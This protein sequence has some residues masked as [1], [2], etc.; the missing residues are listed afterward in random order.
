MHLAYPQSA[1]RG[2]RVSIPI[3]YGRSKSLSLDRPNHW[4]SHKWDV[5]KGLGATLRKRE[6]AQVELAARRAPGW[7]R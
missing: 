1:V 4:A 2:R 6:R 3:Q 5:R 7:E